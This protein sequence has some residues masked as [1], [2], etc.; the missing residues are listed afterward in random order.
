LYINNLQGKSAM[1]NELTFRKMKGL[2]FLPP[3]KGSTAKI[4]VG[5]NSEGCV[6]ISKTL[7]YEC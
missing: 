5:K 7:P 2:S 4:K 1:E 6:L 3:Y